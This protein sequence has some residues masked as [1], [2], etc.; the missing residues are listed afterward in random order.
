[1]PTPPGSLRKFSRLALVLLF[2]VGAIVLAVSLRESGG[3]QRAGANDW[4]GLAGSPRSSVSVGER[5]I[6]VLHAQCLHLARVQL[7]PCH[8]RLFRRA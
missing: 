5:V 3:G 4:A 8:Q 6:V 7:H 1:M 2:F